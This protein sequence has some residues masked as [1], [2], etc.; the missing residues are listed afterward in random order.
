M[1]QQAG[2]RLA[3]ECMTRPCLRIPYRHYRHVLATNQAYV[4]T[5][6]VEEQ[7]C[8]VTVTVRTLRLLNM[9]DIETASEPSEE[10]SA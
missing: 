10:V 6:L 8:T 3:P 1:V 4:V 9:H 2:L 5:G 7:F